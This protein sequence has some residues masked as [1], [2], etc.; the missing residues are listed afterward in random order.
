MPYPRE[1]YVC[2]QDTIPQ[3]LIDIAFKLGITLAG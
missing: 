3:N 1:M 2:Y